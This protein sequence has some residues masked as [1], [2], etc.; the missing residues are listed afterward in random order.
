M[1]IQIT[2]T[3]DIAKIDGFECRRWKGVTAGGVECEVFVH[4][5]AVSKDEDCSQFDNELAEQLPP[6]SPAVDLRFLLP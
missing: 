5:I 1:E 6:A 2:A 4:R 3:P